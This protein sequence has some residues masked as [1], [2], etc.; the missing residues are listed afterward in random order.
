MGM[1]GELTL[2]GQIL[3]TSGIKEKVLL[4]KR[5]QIGEVVVPQDNRPEVDM[6]QDYIREGITF[7]FVSHF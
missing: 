2:S 3:R 4:A 7:H 5:E 1:T 6:L